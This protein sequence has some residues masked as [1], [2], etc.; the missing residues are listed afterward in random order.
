MQEMFGSILLLVLL[1]PLGSFLG[2][3]WAGW[4]QHFFCVMLHDWITGGAQVNPAV[5]VG[6]I[7]IGWNTPATAVVRVLGQLIGGTIAFPMMDKLLP[8]YVQMGGPQLAE[9]VD[10]TE[11]MIWETCLTFCLLMWVFVCATRV[12]LPAQRPLIAAG[13]RGLIFNGGKTGPA[14][15]PMIGWSWAVFVNPELPGSDHFLVYWLAPCLG[16]WLMAH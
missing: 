13:I 11:G 3:T 6:T 12:G 15:N 16:K 1:F 14:M 9:G 7:P 10:V 2:D 5:S 8:A 4:I